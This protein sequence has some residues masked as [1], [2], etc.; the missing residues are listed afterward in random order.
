MIGR[1]IQFSVKNKFF[2]LLFIIAWISWGGWSLTQIPIGSV[3]DITN[4]QVQ[5]LTTSRNL[6]TQD[7]EQY[8]TYPIELEMAN[9]PGIKEIR[10]I[11][12]F[13]LSV[14]TI[15]FDDDM[16]TYV[17]RQLIAEK[18]KSASEKIPAGYGTPEMGPITTG[19]G[20]IYQYVL[21]TKPGYKN[22]YSAMELRTIQDW[23]VKRQLSGIPGVVEVNTWGGFLKQYEVSINPER[24]RAMNV[25][26]HEVHNAVAN[27]N[28]VTGGGYIEKGNQAFFIRGEGMVKNLEDIENTV[29]KNVSGIPVLISD[30]AQV[31]FG[32]ATRFGAITGNGEGEKVLGQIMMLK[33]TSTQKVIER[34]KQRVAEVQ[35]M[36][37]EGVYIN[38]FLE[39]SELI[40]KTTFTISE[41]LILGA[42]I[43]IFVLVLLLGNLRAG[44]IV[45]SVIPLSLL[46]GIGLMNQFGLSANLMSL[47]A[48]DFGIIIDGAVIIIEFIVFKVTQRR[49]E[50]LELIGK[51]LQKRK[52]Q[53]TIESASRMMKTAFFGQIIILIVFVPILSLSG[54]EGKMFK[55]MV[56]S[57]SFALIGAMILSL[58]FIPAMASLVCQPR[59]QKKDFSDKIMDKIRGAY[60][61]VIQWALN[62][63]LIVISL[64][65]ALLSSSVY[66]F[67]IMGGEFIPTLDEGDFVV[68]PILKTGTSL[69]KTVET[70]TQIENILLNE[71]S[72]VEQVITRIGAAEVP[73]DPMSMEETDVMIKLRPKEEWVTAKTKDELADKMKSAMSVIPGIGFEFTQPIEM[74]FNELITG[75]RAD[76]AIKI[77]GENMAILD[78]L[79]N[80]VRALVVGLSGAADVSVEKVTGLPQMAVTYNRQKIAQYGLN[81]HELNTVLQ[82]AFGGSTAGVVFEGEKRFDLVVRLD[83]NHRKGI[84]NV[85][86]LYIDLPNGGQVP[87]RE[88]ATIIN[89]TG[90]A[91]ISRDNTQ[92][93]IVVGINVRNRDMESLVNEI[94][95]IVDDQVTLP[96]G[97]SISY[98]GQFENLQAA[99][100]RLQ[101]AV[102]IALFLIFLM[103]YITFQSVR[104]ALMVFTAIPLSAIGGVWLLWLRDLPFSISAGVGFI[105][106]FGVAV[107]NGIVLIDYFND[108]KEQGVDDLKERV[109]QG[110]IQRLRPV[111]L[112]ASAAALGFIPMALSA[113]A[114]AEVQRPLATVVI[115]GLITATLLTLI[116]LPVIYTCFERYTLSKVNKNTLLI[117]VLM[118]FGAT[119]TSIGQDNRLSREQAIQLALENNLDLKAGALQVEEKRYLENTAWDLGK[120]NFYYGYDENNRAQNNN[121]LNVLG[122]QQTIPFPSTLSLG[123]QIARYDTDLAKANLRIRERVVRK[124]VVLAYEEVVYHQSRLDQYQF[125]DSL[126]STFAA[127]SRRRFELGE[128]N[129]LEKLTAEAKY[130]QIAAKKDQ[131]ERD[132][133]MSE[134]QLKALLQPEGDI[135]IQ[136]VTMEKQPIQYA[137]WN[138]LLADHEGLN[139]LQLLEDRSTTSLKLSKHQFL[140]DLNLE[141]FRGYGKGDNAQ[142]FN[143]Y[144]FGLS[145]PLF[146]KS[147]KGHVQSQKARSDRAATE[148]SAY[149]KSL[150][151]Q[152]LQLRAKL[153][154]YNQAVSYYEDTGL[155]MADELQSLGHKSYLSG[156]SGYLEYVQSL[157]NA[158]QINLGYLDNLFEYNKVV[159]EINYLIPQ[160]QK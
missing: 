120:T 150:Q 49:G 66:L 2:V 59:G 42:L 149:E 122:I 94:Q 16:G 48:I 25:T 39:R 69:G 40:N 44:L 24:L 3:P 86:N 157:D 119:G 6:S 135:S 65:I 96:T 89:K 139:Y 93:R 57:F 1:I 54:I 152:Y 26:L 58:T 100:S 52:D 37:P 10:S 79:A 154:K 23:I 22:R 75:V 133:E 19:L 9:L 46:F 147:R 140:P 153:D 76:V 159:F 29:V 5:V 148:I 73:T 127:A 8:I 136:G 124:Q 11:S 102:P 35:P 104:Q 145:V 74:R 36:L 67:T 88:V 143:G 110:T 118:V 28:E 68:Q 30:I 61:P 138:Q 95:G 78:R 77:Y 113:S 15:V 156:E 60:L 13:G 27:N 137:D 50:L 71:F 99:L 105:A 144:Q 32:S 109:I 111:I 155:K 81:I 55:P 142:Q 20:E 7:I 80:Q 134:E 82:M 87:F 106:L 101:V 41:N 34:V 112:T 115:G 18:I 116:V 125:L 126:Y 123:S 141:Y 97:Y 132:I 56:L 98:G 85:K 17:P 47:G 151:F 51:E 43:V 45:A 33:G 92:R 38:P 103:L 129:Y 146:F 114:G 108:L 158:S 62:Y 53:I 84:D 83:A 4:N 107:L 91:M 117:L 72:E 31:K 160:S 70:V 130:L 14:V 90:P 121:P 12:K 21:D 128:S 63:R 131:I 64:A